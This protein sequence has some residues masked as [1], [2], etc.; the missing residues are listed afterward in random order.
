MRA[1]VAIF[2]PP[3]IRKKILLAAQRLS[4]AHR[5]RWTRPE[6]I[7]LTLK[8]LGEVRKDALDGLRTA[9]V[10]AC[11]GHAPFD[12]TLAGLGAFPSARRARVLWA[13]VGAG[14]NRLRSL[15]TDIDVALAPLGFEREKRPY[16]PHLTIGRMR[17]R[18]ASLDL[19]ST[20][21]LRFRVRHV[22]LME[23]TLTTEG[24]TYR[25]VEDFALEGE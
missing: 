1:F 18:P 24:A 4:S 19:P 10:E 6:N 7:H 14:S 11:A 16:I 17:G 20:T 3:E 22:E 15:A 13:G 9:L 12:V 23:S 21:G 2:P 25:T 5:V 8:F